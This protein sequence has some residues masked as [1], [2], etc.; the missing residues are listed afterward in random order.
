MNLNT[1]VIKML[2]V[3]LRS[4]QHLSS[5]AERQKHRAVWSHTLQLSSW[6]CHFLILTLDELILLLL[7]FFVVVV[8]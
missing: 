3:P 5:D 6:P 1:G 7:L 4:E 2:S 8:E